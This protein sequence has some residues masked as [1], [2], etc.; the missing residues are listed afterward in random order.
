MPDWARLLVVPAVGGLVVGP[1]VYFFAR[2]AEGH[3]VP[4]VM[5]AVALHG[6]RIRPRVALVKA[7]ASGVCIGT[8]GSELWPACWRSAFPAASISRRMSGTGY[9]HGSGPSRP[10]VGWCSAVSAS[11]VSRSMVFR[12]CSVAIRFLSA[13]ATSNTSYGGHRA[14]P[15]RHRHRCRAPEYDVQHSKT[16]RRLNLPAGIASRLRRRLYSQPFKLALYPVS[17]L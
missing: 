17:R 11:S 15:R 8:G 5:E 16:A 9:A 10:S 7:L 13:A 3:G 4:E 1:L 2:E 14:M 6:G 12:R